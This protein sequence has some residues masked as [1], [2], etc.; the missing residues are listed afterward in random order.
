MSAR[1]LAIPSTVE[2]SLLLVDDDP[3]SIQA[4]SRM[5]SQYGDQRFAVSGEDALRLARERVPDLMLLDV[6]MP[7]MNGF[8]IYDA[9]QA[10]P[11]LAHV[12]VIFST[13]H[14]TLPVELTALSKGAVDF[15]TKPP[16]AAQLTARVRAQLRH[17]SQIEGIRRARSA[18]A[19]PRRAGSR[20]PKI[21]IVD[22]DITALRILQNSLKSLGEFFFAL[23]GS[24]AIA[25]AR[26]IQPDLIL[27]DA[28]MPEVDGFAVCK[29]LKAE[30]EFK[31]VPIVFVSCFKDARSER[32]ALDTGAADFVGKPYAPAVL[33][34]RVNNLLQLKR[35]ADAELEATR[36]HWRVT[37]QARVAEVV[38]AASDAIVSF[39][40][41]ERVVL[42]NAAA[43]RLFGLTR[44]EV[45]GHEFGELVTF[46][47][48]VRAAAPGAPVRSH[49]VRAD[50]VPLAVE[51]VASHSGEGDA[52]L[53]TVMIRD[54]SDRERFEAESRARAAAETAS[55]ISARMLAH[56]TQEMGSPLRSL[57]GHAKLMTSDR[58]QPLSEDQSRRLARVVA[59]AQRLDVL[60]RDVIDFERLDPQ[61][62]RIQLNEV[63]VPRCAN[64]AVTQVAEL[65]EQAGVSVSLV[66]PEGLGAVMADAHRLTRCLLNL[67]RNAVSYNRPG[68]WVEVRLRSEG[69]QLAIAVMDGGIGMDAEQLAH[70]FEPF[71][72]LGRHVTTVPGAGLALAITRSLVEAMGGTLL[73][74]SQA[75]HGS[76]FTLRLPLAPCPE[77]I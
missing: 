57:L 29:T 75:G 9:F 45:L 2:S 70:L 59:D 30:P 25:V 50:G 24:E 69:Q 65:A 63:D 49:V 41:N 27:L 34:S 51:A 31:F 12:P 23:S 11:D 56:I 5:L 10:D 39:D 47:A 20:A 8:D 21:L 18:A 14:D 13:S 26:R 53:T 46:G 37:G 42:C 36:E 52:R 62:P 44:D 54:L 67:L 6:D 33:R 58:L 64:L 38:E 77:L 66:I 16:I 61:P 71:N 74:T 17:R 60:L 1:T 40:D 7:G 55:R 22:D 76:A 35:T 73:V 19:P 68:G 15:I 48:E 28:R 3:A 4:T 43:C 32:R 72:R